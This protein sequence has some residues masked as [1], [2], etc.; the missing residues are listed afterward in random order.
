MWC[1]TYNVIPWQKWYSHEPPLLRTNE[2]LLYCS[3]ERT[4]K[5]W[6]NEEVR[7]KPLILNL[8]TINRLFR[9]RTTK[10]NNFETEKH[11]YYFKWQWFIFKA[12]ITLIPY[13]EEIR[14]L[15][16]WQFWLVNIFYAV[17][18]VLT[19]R[20]CHLQRRQPIFDFQL[21]RT[22]VAEHKILWVFALPKRMTQNAFQRGD[23][24]MNPLEFT[25]N[26]HFKYLSIDLW[27]YSLVFQWN[28]SFNCN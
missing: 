26:M 8:S 20:S 19:T 5:V 27:Q 28:S 4:E 12:Y 3:I 13:W 24:N 25:L 18:T 14:D 17:A 10:S 15:F 6:T 1:T 21:C 9:N 2:T 7:E 22:R 16:M 11:W 23:E